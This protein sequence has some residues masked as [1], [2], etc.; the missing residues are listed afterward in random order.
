MMVAKNAMKGKQIYTDLSP[1]RRR[2]KLSRLL[3]FSSLDTAL[4]ARNLG[5][6]ASP[7]R[8]L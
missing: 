3:S 5:S 8:Y 7:E 6:D 2:Y 1:L 4:K